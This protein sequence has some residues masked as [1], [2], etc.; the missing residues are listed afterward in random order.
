MKSSKVVILEINAIYKAFKP[1]ITKYVNLKIRDKMIAEELINDVFVK[2]HTSL[3]TYDSKKA[4]FNTWIFNI[5]KNVLI[6]HFRKKSL[7]TT[8]LEVSKQDD[9][10]DTMS[11]TLPVATPDRNPLE[12]MISD[13]TMYN[14]Q[15]A[16]GHLNE[17]Q[18]EMLTM[19]ALDNLTYEEIAAMLNMPMGTVKGTI[20]NA[21]TR[22]KEILGNRI[23]VLA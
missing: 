18:R 21:R 1:A 13:E 11:E 6:D 9:S 4:Q 16:M 14:V 20:F 19:Y 12:S 7:E 8:S 23:P 10:E 22:L 2:V 3:R 5:A 17:T 15:T